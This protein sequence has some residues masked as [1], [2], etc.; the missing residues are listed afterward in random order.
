MSYRGRYVSYGNKSITLKD[1]G[2]ISSL[3][4]RMWTDYSGFG[5]VQV[6][7]GSKKVGPEFEGIFTHIDGYRLTFSDH[8]G[9]E[10]I[11]L[12]GDF[13]FL[14]GSSPKDNSMYHS[15]DYN[16]LIVSEKDLTTKDILNNIGM[17]K[18][19]I[20]VGQEH[21]QEGHTINHGNHISPFSRGKKKQSSDNDE[22]YLKELY[23]NNKGVCTCGGA[24]RVQ[25][26]S[27]LRWLFPHPDGAQA[28]WD[29]MTNTDMED[30]WTALME[31]INDA[32]P[33]ERDRVLSGFSGK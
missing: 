10:Q 28:A 20:G 14:R 9:G 11:L 33:I 12:L 27:K 21:N 3:G 2:Y 6:Y 23:D 5:P 25:Y 31:I 26:N 19:G 32:L 16:Y 17:I 30:D 24:V 7:K 1:P 18:V 13:I 15:I 8:V 4:D 22:G 29:H